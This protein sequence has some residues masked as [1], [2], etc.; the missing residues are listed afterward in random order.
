MPRHSLRVLL[1]VGALLLAGC[2]GG[3]S[4]SPGSPTASADRS[5]TSGTTTTTTATTGGTV[6]FYV[7]D[8]KNAIGDFRHLNVTVSRVGFERTG[9][10]EESGGWVEFS[11]GNT[12]LDLTTLQGENATLV[13]AYRLPNAT[14]GKVFVYVSEVNA[15]L[16]DGER[17][18]V[19][20][21]SEKLQ[22][23]DEFT[24]RDGTEVN[25]VFDISVVKAGNSGKYVLKPVISESGTTVPINPTGAAETQPEAPSNA[26]AANDTA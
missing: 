5:G 20:L 9:T 14:Y 22:L 11:A 8:E 10:G 1:I 7:S 25:F 23:N 17:V 2:A 18:R 6:A 4:D 3:I 13:D 12:T 24:V 15:T 26:T 21:P 19:K 16:E